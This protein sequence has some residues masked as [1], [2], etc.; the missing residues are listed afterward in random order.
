MCVPCAQY[1]PASWHQVNHEEE[2]GDQKHDTTMSRREGALEPLKV[3]AFIAPVT[4]RHPVATVRLDVAAAV[5]SELVKEIGI[6]AFD[7]DFLSS[8]L[9]LP[10]AV[11]PR[12]SSVYSELVDPLTGGFF[13][14]IATFE[15]AGEHLRPSFRS[16][17]Y[18][19]RLRAFA[20]I[21][22]EHLSTL[23]E[24]EQKE[25]RGETQVTLRLVVEGIPESE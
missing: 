6:A 19:F 16:G 8:S 2:A 3:I 11:H 15:L 7:L 18:I 21:I 1:Y 14:I 17:E 4:L 23:P 20:A 5:T 24:S 25:G 10:Q 12:V 13:H 22:D 9:P